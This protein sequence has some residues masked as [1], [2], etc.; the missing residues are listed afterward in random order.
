MIP[1]ADTVRSRSVP[2][3][4]LTIILINIVVFVYEVYLSQN[5]IRG[6]VT[7]LDRF[8][9]E[10]GNIPACTFD[11]LGRNVELSAR[12]QA[13]CAGQDRPLLT[14]FT[15]MFMHGG[16]LHLAGNMLFLWIFGDNVED[17]MG[18][19][20]YALFYLLCGVIA[21]LTHGA[22]DT[23]SL[24]PAIGASGAIAGVMGA[25]LVLF[26]RAMVYVVLGIIL[27]PAPL[28]AWVLIGF[29]I[30]LQVFYGA[31]SLGVDTA[32]GGVAYFAH[33]GG[34]IAGALLVR[35]FVVGRA[36]RLRALRATQRLW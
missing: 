34:F 33:I 11:E 8:I 12:G 6:N 1:V 20:R 28:P 4:N 7:D 3:V 35:L 18:H 22:I 2:Y 9:Y 23:M 31:A 26:P 19:L 5:V 15:A 30:V 36:R 29:W 13:L 16:W 24:Q 27:I 14:I 17:A 32:A 21:A 10:W 25:Y